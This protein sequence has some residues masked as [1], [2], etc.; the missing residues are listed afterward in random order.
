MARSGSEI[1]HAARQARKA[2]QRGDLDAAVRWLS[3]LER[4]L[5]FAERTLALHRPKKSR[6]HRNRLRKDP[7]LSPP[8]QG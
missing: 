1:R 6:H 5:A 3:V 7:P 4:Y 2:T 8:F